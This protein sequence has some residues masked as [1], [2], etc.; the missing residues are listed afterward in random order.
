MTENDK[1]TEQAKAELDESVEAQPSTDDQ[2]ADLIG[3]AESADGNNAYLALTQLQAELF[4]VQ[5]KLSTAEEQVLR[6]HAEMQNVKRRAQQD[7]EKAHR[8][9]L[10][11]FADSLLPIV[12]SLERG[13][14]SAEA[15]D[16]SHNAMKEG[17]DLTLKLFIDTLKKFNVKQVNPV[18]E[19]FDPLLHQAVSQIE[20]ADQ[21]PGSVLN[22]FQKGYTLND[23]LIRPAMVVVVKAPAGG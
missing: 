19:P 18:G 11:K 8:F 15:A 16:G 17:M 9:G 14:E 22:V 12:D 21:E 2:K 23:R 7:V 13:L 1:D 5:E 6:M 20:S 4:K 10:D 3:D